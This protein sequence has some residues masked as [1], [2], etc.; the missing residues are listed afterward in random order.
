MLDKLA[1]I[2][3]RFDELGIALTNPEVVSDNKKYTLL[4]KEYRSLEKIVK[5][6]SLYAKV[7]DD[8]DFNREMINS[9]DLE[10]RELAK[11]ELPGLQEQKDKLEKQIRTML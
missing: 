9:D 3:A 11:E 6:R 7:L 1:A 5:I 8:I 10:M 4:S 2:K